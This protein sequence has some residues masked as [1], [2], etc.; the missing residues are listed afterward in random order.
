MNFLGENL[1]KKMGGWMGSSMLIGGRVT[2]ISACLSSVA[3]YQMSMR[4]LHK[5]NI[6]NL[7]KL[8]RSFFWAGCAN[9]RK[10]SLCLEI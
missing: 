9:K 1:E 6:E 8:T 2:K 7:E 10:Y 4:L 3:I 5:I